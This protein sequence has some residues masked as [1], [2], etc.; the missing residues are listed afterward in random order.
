MIEHVTERD[1]VRNL[2]RYLRR[3]SYENQ[4]IPPVPVD[5]I[6]ETRT[7]ESLSAFQKSVGLPVTGRAD[8][9]TW[10]RLFAEYEKRKREEDRRVSPDFFPQ[11]PADY[12]TTLGERNAFISLLQFVLEELRVVYD[13]LPPFPQNGVFDA[14]SSAA[15][16]EFQRIGGLPQSGRVNR[17]VWNRLAEE[18]GFYAN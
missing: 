15:V 10:E 6:F 13:T 4:A 3:L 16:R 2:Q 11:N 8:R 1:A 7:R 9:I 17:N 12:E 14:E 18:Y 5:G